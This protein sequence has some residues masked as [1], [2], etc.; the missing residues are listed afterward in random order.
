MTNSATLPAPIVPPAQEGAVKGGPVGLIKALG[1]SRII[2]M[3]VV[4]LAT[5]GFFTYLILKAT[6]PEYTILFGDLDPSAAGQIVGRLEGMNVGHKLSADGR[7]IMVPE[8]EVGR[9]RMELAQDGLPASGPAG[10]ELLDNTNAFTST[11]ILTN[12]NLKRALEGELART[13][14]ALQSVASARVMLVQPK[15]ELFERDQ[16]KPSASV[17]L[18]LRSL[19]GLEPRQVQGIRQLVASAVPGLSP[20][21]ITI[22]D[23]RGNLLARAKEPG[24]DGLDEGDIE[25]QRISYENR[26]R[27]K[28]MNLLAPTVGADRVEVEVH[29]D[30]DFDD[31]TVTSE[32]FDPDKA[33]PRSTQTTEEKTERTEKEAKEATTVANNLPTA[34]AQPDSGAGSSEKTSRTEETTNYEISKTVTSHVRRGPVVKRMTIAVQLAELQS[35]GADGKAVAAPRSEAELAQLTAL[36]KTATGFNAERGD[37]VEVVS[38]SMVAEAVPAEAAGPS[39]LD[40]LDLGRIG[41]LATIAAF[42]LLVIFLGLRPLTRELMKAGRPALAVAAAEAMPALPAAAGEQPL[43]LAEDQVLAAQPIALAELEG[44]APAQAAPALPE[45]VELPQIAGPVRSD[46]LTATNDL[47]RERPEETLR[48]LRGWLGS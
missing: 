27:Q 37:V 8:N 26:L 12:L 34:Q 29:A 10:Y 30:M 19:G 28:V 23:D 35:V 11:D 16:Q 22:V 6:E 24:A 38:R 13:I 20:D 15:R 7:A 39:F 33:V 1:P 44:Q 18:K 42:A 31:E 47:I 41:E 3:G 48:V 40:R 21:R 32:S 46:L 43:L 45:M 4:A 9:L 17:F 36:V 2:A 5:L 25:D 14:G